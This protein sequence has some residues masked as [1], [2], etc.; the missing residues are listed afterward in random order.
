MKQ[1]YRRSDLPLGLRSLEVT[2][3]RCAKAPKGPAELKPQQ[4]LKIHGETQGTDQ[5]FHCN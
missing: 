4:D 2:R 3:L 1:S 5:K